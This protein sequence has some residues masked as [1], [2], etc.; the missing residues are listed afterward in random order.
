MTLEEIAKFYE[1]NLSIEKVEEIRNEVKGI[2]EIET[3][4]DP[5]KLYINFLLLEYLESNII[6]DN[7][8]N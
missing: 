4:V 3:H 5:R 7:K 2:Y 6:K 8:K 1:S